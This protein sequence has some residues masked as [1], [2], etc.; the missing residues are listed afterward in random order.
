MTANTIRNSLGVL[1]DE[2]DND[3]A[4]SELRETLGYTSEDG[5]V[6]PGELGPAALA[7]LLEAA[8]Q[9]HEMRREYE[10]VA[11]LL[12]IESALASGDRE[13]ELVA[14][15]A[16]VRDDILLD[17]AGAL[18]AYRR[19][20]TMR[21][22]DTNAAEAIERSEAK[23][24][25]WKDLAQRYYTES[26][27]AGDA[28]FKSSLLVSAAETAYRYGRPE[29][30]AKEK[31]EAEAA[32]PA[33]ESSPKS[34]RGGKKNKKKAPKSPDSSRSPESIPESARNEP[35]K[36]RRELTEKIIGL[37]RDALT[38]DPK[39]RR[40]VLLQERI[41][42]DERRWTDLVAALELFATESNAKDEKIAASIR[43]ARVLTKKLS[44]KARAIT[45]YERVLDLS[46]GH[47]EATSALVNHFTDNE[48]WDH[49]VSLYE[50]QLAGGGVRQGQEVGVILQVAMINW[51]MRNKPEAAEPYFERLR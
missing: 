8:R 41:L 28:S 23:R 4:W 26:K 22:N 37:L 5:S 18:A 2:P 3:Q 10:A 31:K 45:V 40:A 6:D 7:Q 48:M 36:G 49:L 51:R 50:G 13:A 21:P 44:D 20:L 35:S 42:R 32:K 33:E 17:D 34:L 38:L 16:T 9:A 19:L 11:E 12:E 47:P 14:E 24:A 46:P 15:L 43:L 39:N 29:I 25:K 30:V 1:Q 27:S